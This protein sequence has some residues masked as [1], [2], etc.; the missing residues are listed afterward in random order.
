[1]IRP[2]A[3]IS[4]VMIA[5][6]P[7]GPAPGACRPAANAY[8]SATGLR[9]IR[10]AEHRR[11]SVTKTVTSRAVTSSVSPLREF[12]SPLGEFLAFLRWFV[13]GHHR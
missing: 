12:V 2:A 6:S 4:A 10:V 11:V 5:A 8:L 9:L 3:C 13:T 7:L 1:M